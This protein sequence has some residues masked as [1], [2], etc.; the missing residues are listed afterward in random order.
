MLSAAALVRR[1]VTPELPIDDP[2]FLRTLASGDHDA[3]RLLY[4]RFGRALFS[5][6]LE[7]VGDPGTAEEVV[8]DTFVAAWRQ[9]GRFEGRSTLASWLFGIARRQARD[10]M[11]RHR[12]AIEPAERLEEIAAEDGEPEAEAIA[13]A[14]RDELRRALDA[15]AMAHREVLV[16]TFA[17][18]LSGPEVA[19]VLGVPE[20]TVKSRLFAARRALRAELESRRPR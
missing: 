14:S 3:V 17:H 13:S 11:R 12:P 16:L 8:Q 9:A 4:G 6:V 10:R 15:I 5:Y 7:I 1:T 2:A 19:A 20:G 18:E